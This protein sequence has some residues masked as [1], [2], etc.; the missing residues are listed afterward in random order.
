[1]GFILPSALAL[2]GLAIPIIIFYMLKLR[3]QP[4]Q[5]SSLL[6]WEQVLADRQANAPWQML[7]RHLLLLL[8]LLILALLVMALARPY[9]IIEAKVQG[10]VVILLDASASM[11][12][13]DLSP[14]RFAR[15]KEIVLETVNSLSPDDTVTL[16]AVE[17]TPRVLTTAT[18]DRHLIQQALSDSEAT[19]GPVD[20]ESAF[21]L[22][23]AN[24]AALPESSILVVSDGASES[25]MMG[26][27]LAQSLNL[28][29]PIESIPVGQASDNQGVV[30]MALRDG[31]EGPEL[32]VRVFNASSETRQRLVDIDINGQVYDARM[33]EMPAQTEASFTLSGLPLEARQI[34]A[35]LVGDDILPADDTAWVIRQPAPTKIL[36]VSKGNRFLERALSLLPDVNIQR[37]T[38]DQELPQSRFDLMIFDR[39]VPREIPKTNLL[40]IAPPTSSTLF[41]V[42]GTVTRTRFTSQ[43]REHPILN[44]VDLSAIH[45]GKIQQI[46]PPPWSRVLAD[47]SQGPLLM[48]GQSHEQRLI[49]LAFDLFQSDWPLK[50]EFPIFILNSARWLVPGQI[51]EQA[52][53]HRAGEGYHLPAATVSDSFIV[54]D[55]LGQQRSVPTDTTSFN[56]T[57]ALGLYQ[58]TGQLANG[59]T[60]QVE[61]FAIN[62]LSAEESDITPNRVNF[63]WAVNNSNNLNNTPA[64]T[65]Y[66]GHWEWWWILVLLGLAVLGLEWWVYWRGEV[67]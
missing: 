16:I 25:R 32:F 20:W 2:A 46:K 17:H 13:T 1:M 63:S 22:A 10:N 42:T 21:A 33:L 65:S 3:R 18:T 35:N 23:A 58:I 44:Y 41:E 11:Q 67:R 9:F 45:I 8:Q 56:Q 15:A 54:R 38:P 51:L 61:Q 24:A 26:Q 62:L 64:D 50:I 55:P 66:E 57:D 48:A 12:A 39:T 29:I 60:K 31:L 40:F 43:L 6:L 53:I 19:N 7:K 27:E 49:I 4:I 34:Q 37:A 30:A 5:V 52:E 47:S 14:N 28:A 36:L 59:E